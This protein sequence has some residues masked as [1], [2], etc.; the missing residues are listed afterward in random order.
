MGK[1]GKIE[2]FIFNSGLKTTPRAGPPG[3]YLRKH[4]R[5]VPLVVS[6]LMLGERSSR[7]P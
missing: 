2:F 7:R 5:G 1:L 6:S 4:P 3:A